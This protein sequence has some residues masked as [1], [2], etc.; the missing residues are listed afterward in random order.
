MLSSAAQV[1]VHLGMTKYALYHALG[2]QI[3]K[4]RALW[5]FELVHAAV[6]ELGEPYQA[7]CMVEHQKFVLLPCV[8]ASDA[9][10]IVAM[11]G[12]CELAK[13]QL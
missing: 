4:R 13:K 5:S 7:V 12:G 1:T 8:Q 2:L 3:C 6:M 10:T 11:C 9:A